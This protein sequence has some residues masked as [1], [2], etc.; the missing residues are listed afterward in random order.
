MR[1]QG[2][3][4]DSLSPVTEA[5]GTLRLLASKG[6]HLIWLTGVGLTLLFAL[7]ICMLMRPFYGSTVW[8]HF[9]I[10]YPSGKAALCTG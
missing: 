1:G 4:E 7:L 2:H 3:E 9:K 5:V 6:C 8:I 10:N